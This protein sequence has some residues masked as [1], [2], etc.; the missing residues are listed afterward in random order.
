MSVDLYSG[1]TEFDGNAS[2]VPIVLPNA[3]DANLPDSSVTA[4]RTALP[5]PKEM[6]SKEGTLD[7]LRLMK[8]KQKPSRSRGVAPYGE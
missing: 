5:R 6:V 8:R 1:P 3:P 4:A 2:C 7:I